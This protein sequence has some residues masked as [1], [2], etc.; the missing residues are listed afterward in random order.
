MIGKI[1]LIEIEKDFNK[2]AGE[3]LI[4]HNYEQNKYWVNSK[5]CIITGGSGLVGSSFDDG[6]KINSSDCNL[7]NYDESY[8]KIK[9]F[10]PD[11]IIHCCY[12]WWFIL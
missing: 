5:S 12:G 4:K 8:K 11:S 10:N 3:S 1:F 7:L 2:Y 6:I 9:S